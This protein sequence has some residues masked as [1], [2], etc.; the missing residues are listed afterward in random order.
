MN[1]VPAL[2]RGLSLLETIAAATQP[3][4]FVDLWR[5]SELPKASIARILACL[6]DRGYLSADVPGGGYRM[7]PRAALL[8]SSPD[9]FERLSIAA[10][11]AVA[12]LAERS[13]QSAIA[14]VFHERGFTVMASVGVEDGVRLLE[15]GVHRNDLSG[16]PWGMLAWL[17][18][19]A[20]NRD[21]AKQDMQHRDAFESDIKQREVELAERGIIS[22]GSPS[23]R[24]LAAPLKDSHNRIIG[25]IGIGGIASVLDSQV[26]FMYV[27]LREAAERLS[28][29]L[30]PFFYEARP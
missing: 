18:L 14:H 8:S 29:D 5:W 9:R 26:E 11:P 24:R 30:A 21:R 19:D 27:P 6:R 16:G 23:I 4:T 12:Q 15:A 13:G 25:S 1:D 22:D 3:P 2:T 20:D 7:G 10:Q 28:S 17:G